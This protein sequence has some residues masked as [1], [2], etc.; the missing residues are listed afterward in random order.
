MIQSQVRTLPQLDDLNRFF[1]ISGRDGRLRFLRC[2]KC[3]Y[4]LHPPGVI[5]PV[6]MSTSL[7]PEP[8]SG[9]G[10]IEAYSV[11]CQPWTAGMEVP[12]GIAIVGLDEQPALRLTTNIVGTGLD[13]VAIGQR[14]RVMFD[15]CGDVW[16]PLFT[17][18]APDGS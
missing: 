16:L 5:C 1:W 13:Q 17:P 2:Q 10:T 14:V 8:V 9:L 15:A 4:W 12:F 11:N 3:R 6:C 18:V 7:E